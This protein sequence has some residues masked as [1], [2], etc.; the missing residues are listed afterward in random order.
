MK[1]KRNI[2]LQYTL[3]TFLVIALVSYGLARLL[4]LRITDNLVKVHLEL[5]PGIVEMGVRN[6]PEIYRFLQSPPGTMAT[7]EILALFD[8]FLSLG[9]IFRLK[10]WGKDAS[11]MWSDQTDIIGQKFV[12]DPLFQRAM[13]G[14]LAYELSTPEKSENIKEEG[15]GV[16]LEIYIPVVRDDQVIGVLELYESNR[17]L[18]GQIRQNNRILWLLVSGAGIVLYILLFSI[19]FNAY[20]R[21]KRTSL[22][23][24]QTQDVT[25]F[26]MA[27]QAEMH[28]RQ[29]GYH[30]ERTSQYVELL[31]WEL[32]KKAQY[33]SYLTDD[34]IADLVKSSPLHDIGKVAVS[35]SILRKPG[36]LTSE[37][38][39][40]MKRHCQYGAMILRKAEEKLSFQSFLKIAIQLTMY[41][42]EWWDGRGYPHGLR[43][44]D[45][46]V[47]ARI[48]TL[49]DVYD[50]LRSERY[51]KRAFPH[52][53]CC[54]IIREEK[55]THFDPL[56]VEA[57][58]RLEEKFKR[59]SEKLVNAVTPATVSG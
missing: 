5:F 49:A 53:R 51:Y 34:Y 57:F 4:S 56:V 2:L 52:E 36:K 11:I 46:P 12:D 22:Q 28:D 15:L 23:L 43:Q 42:H 3:V 35:D 54:A 41:H 25:I 1:L 50:A 26:A 14:K 47:S 17:D 19:F 6:N 31:A 48:M 9:M 45:I 37:E 16:L 33:R 21:Q 39:E 13:Q 18:Y 20:Q 30:L 10:V 44:E 40:Q 58:L 29:T 7:E 38:F 24:T 59:I 8:D 32:S 55:N 27:Y